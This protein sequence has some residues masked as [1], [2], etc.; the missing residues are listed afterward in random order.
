MYHDTAR[1]KSLIV[2]VDASFTCPAGVSF[3]T[4]DVMELLYTIS[5]LFVL[6]P[7]DMTSHVTLRSACISV[8]SQAG[9]RCVQHAI[10]LLD[11]LSAIQSM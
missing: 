9:P 11:G 6:S 7:E 10:M 8:Y 3:V 2:T 1:V 4:F 5:G